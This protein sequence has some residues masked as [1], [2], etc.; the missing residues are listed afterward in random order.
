MI[1]R[2]SVVDEGLISRIAGLVEDA[3][4]RPTNTFGYTIWSHH[5][6]PMA[7]IAPELARLHGADEEL[8]LIA[9]LLHDYA[10]IK[11]SSMIAEHHAHGANEARAILME[12][13]YPQDRISVVED[14]ILS[15]RSSVP[16]PKTSPE[17]RCLADCDAIVHL[18]ESP[19]LFHVAYFG[20]DYIRATYDAAMNLLA[21]QID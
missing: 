16:Q 4:R 2:E 15:H 10:G 20:K 17:A 11:D 6:R 8:V 9:A 3:C 19:S 18:T 21:A 12:A 7:R 13:D 1:R 5:I 14:A